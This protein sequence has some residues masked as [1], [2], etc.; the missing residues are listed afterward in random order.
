MKSITIQN[1][2]CGG[3]A[4]TIQNALAKIGGLSDVTIDV[5]NSIIEYNIQSFQAELDMKEKLSSLGYP[6]IEDENT[7]AKKAKS[8]ISCAVGRV[9]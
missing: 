1:L 4:N 2:K 5:D 8:Y 7:L 9:S 3:C 6:G